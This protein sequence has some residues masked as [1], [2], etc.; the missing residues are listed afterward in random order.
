MYLV[1]SHRLDSWSVPLSALYERQQIGMV[2]PLWPTGTPDIQV[3]HGS[4]R[5]QRIGAMRHT[6][7]KKCR[8]CP[9]QEA[10][11]NCGCEWVPTGHAD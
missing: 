1:K 8:R 5:V 6:P 10:C 4:S 11:K 7:L 2:W 3:E 9:P